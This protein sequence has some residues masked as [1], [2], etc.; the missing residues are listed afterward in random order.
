MDFHRINDFF[1]ITS[2]ADIFIVYIT[3]YMT[4]SNAVKEAEKKQ[5][6]N[7][8]TYSKKENAQTERK[9]K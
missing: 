2:C 4:S 6:I 1:C 5:N 7:H 3:V 8:I 9:I